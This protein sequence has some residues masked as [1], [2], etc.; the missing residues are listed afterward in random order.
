[1]RTL[2]HDE[3]TLWL[4]READRVALPFATT[5]NE[6]TRDEMSNAARKAP[7]VD[8][9]DCPKPAVIK[10]IWEF[11]VKGRNRIEGYI[12]LAVA[13]SSYKL[14]ADAEELEGYG[15]H[16]NTFPAIVQIETKLE[17]VFFEVK[18]KI[19]SLGAL[20]RQLRTYEC[21]SPGKY[22]VV[23][24]DNTYETILREQGFGFVFGSE[25]QRELNL[26]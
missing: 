21:Y 5:K 8:I 19:E 14:R 23:S 22:V 10:K 25:R 1:M 2:R 18:P 4:D 17:W 6:W 20:I 9:P 7:N 26:D 11:P 16:R 3:L 24:L 13:I 12:D 15:Q